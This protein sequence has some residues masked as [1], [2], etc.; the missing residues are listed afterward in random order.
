[1]FC[2]EI[3][4]RRVQN[5][6]SL[7]SWLGMDPGPRSESRV[8]ADERQ[9]QIAE[10]VSVRGRARIGELSSL[11]GVTEPTIRK[12]LRA[13]QDKGLLKR[14]HGGALA[15]QPTVERE[16]A[17]RQATNT[18]AK[19]AIAR[20]CIRLLHDGDSVFLD[21]GTTVNAIATAIAAQGNGLRLSTLTT[22]LGVA[23]TLADVP[24]VDCVLL[25]GQLRRV[26]G[27]LVGALALENLQRFTFSVA[28][29]GVSGFSEM[30]I[31]VGS[32]AEAAVKADAIERAR[33]VV[34]AVDH[35][36]VG[37]TDFARIAGLDVVDVVVMDKTTPA[38]EELCAGYDIDLVAAGG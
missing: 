15:L 1:M 22:S 11:F 25:G 35:S 20:A 8:F 16:F 13:L 24:G 12:D 21:S 36:K 6:G 7:V 5:G 37:T 17:G 10:L 2:E 4:T 3:E 26:D 31:S 33:R 38:V 34:L 14:T 32:I 28:F 23:N 19:E 30:G 29:I 9:A 18:A 27:A